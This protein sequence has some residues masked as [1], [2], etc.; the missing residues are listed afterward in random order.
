MQDT[1]RDVDSNLLALKLNFKVIDFY[2]VFEFNF[3]S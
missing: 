3:V 1:F 2:L